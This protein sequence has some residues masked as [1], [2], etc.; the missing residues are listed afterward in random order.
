M[1]FYFPTEFGEQMA[2][3]AAA[4]SAIIGLFVMFAPGVTFRLFG[5]QFMTDRR[6]GLV[7]LRSSLGGFYLGFGA[8]ALLLAQP[9]VYLAFGASFALA[10][11]GAILSILS[12]GGATVRNC[13]LLVVHSV[14]AALPLMYV[15][16]LF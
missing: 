3:V 6:D 11:F 12:D 14:L 13:L 5:L 9:M 1:E 16:G 7:L 4:V 2:F 8:T 10:V 15:F